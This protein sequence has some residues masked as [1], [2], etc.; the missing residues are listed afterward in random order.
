MK[1]MAFRVGREL[2]AFET[3]YFSE[4]ARILHQTDTSQSE[5]GRA[6]HRQVVGMEYNDHKRRA[7]D[8]WRIHLHPRTQAVRHELRNRLG[9]FSM[10]SGD[11]RALAIEHGSM[12]GPGALAEAAGYLEDLARRLPG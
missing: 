2:R 9:E 3:G 4:G 6:H 10:R 5:E 7:A 1:E 11:N 8:H 12:V